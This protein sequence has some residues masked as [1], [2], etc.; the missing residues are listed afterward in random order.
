[1]NPYAVLEVE[2]SASETEIRKAYKKQALRY[3]PDKVTDPAEKEVNE[4]KFKEITHAYEI[5]TGKAKD[6]TQY[7]DEGD[8][9]PEFFQPGFSSGDYGS[10]AKPQFHPGQNKDV[11]V[12][13]PLTLFERYNGKNVKFQLSRDVL[14]ENCEG[15]GWRR[16][17]NGSLYEPPQVDCHKCHGEGY[18]ISTVR[19]MFGMVTQQKIWCKTCHFTGKVDAR[20]NSDKNKCSMCHARGLVAKRETIIVPI[21]RG[22]NVGDVV[23]IPGMCDQTLD[24]NLPG[25][26]MFRVQEKASGLRP[27]PQLERRGNDFF[28]TLDLPL[29]DAL[30]GFD[31]RFLTT[32]FDDRTLT[33]SMPRGKVVRPG[34]I[35]KVAGEGWPFCAEGSGT[36]SFGDLYVTVNIVFPPDNWF[37]ERGDLTQLHNLIPASL[38]QSQ[39]EPQPDPQNSERIGNYEVVHELPQK[40]EESSHQ[41]TPEQEGEMPPECHAQ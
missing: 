33:W 19:A 10:T 5:L 36:Y 9:G 1:M 27:L 39:S 38:S 41:F 15:S 32:T 40:P 31:D 35:L 4:V 12:D 14:C 18:V 23:P 2:E 11:F 20:P 37:S 21:L 17:K 29:V 13:V 30:S 16:R 7:N 24:G 22:V 8:F 25:N 3:H 26:L 6:N 34:D 28:M